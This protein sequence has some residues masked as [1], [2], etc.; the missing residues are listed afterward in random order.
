MKL[1]LSLILFVLVL[2]CSSETSISEDRALDVFCDAEM[3]SGTSF[4][5]NGI[6]FKGA[7]TQSTDKARSGKYSS[8]LNKDQ[9]FGFT[10]EVTNVKKG[11]VIEASVWKHTSGNHG[12][13]VI[14]ADDANNDQYEF[15]QFFND[16]Q[17]GW[18]LI[19][20]FFVAMHDYDKVLVYALCANEEEAYFDDFS[21]KVSRNNQ[22]PDDSHPSLEINISDGAYDTLNRFREIALDQQ[23]ITSNLK[24]YINASLTID[25]EDVP[26]ELRLKGDWTDHLKTNKWSFRIKVRKG[27][28]YKGMRTFS[29]QNPITRSFMHEWFAHKIFE[30]EDILTTR[31]IFVPVIINGEKK[32]VYAL[33]EHF[34]KQ[35]L[36]HRKRREGPIVKFD[37]NGVW[38]IHL[39]EKQSNQSQRVPVYQSAEILPFKKNRTYKSPTLTSQFRVAQS[40]MARY[41]NHDP[42][43]GEY[44]DIDA[45]S[46]FIA[47]SDIVNGK[48]GIIWHNQRHYY[49]PV[50]TKLEPI[51]FDC[52]ME[53]NLLTYQ[54]EMFGLGIRNS[55]KLDE[56]EATLLNKE[57]EQKYYEY[58]KKYSSEA[59]IETVFEALEKQI[60]AAEKLL[61][62]EFPSMHL[63]RSFFRKNAMQIRSQLEEYERVRV[64][65]VK[66]NTEEEPF[67]VLGE[68]EIYTDI[69]V[70]ANLE[71]RHL[72]GSVTISLRNYHSSEVE[73]FGYSTKLDK[74]TIVPFV[75]KIRAF[76]TTTD[77]IYVTFPEKPRRLHYR[78]KN[79]PGQ[80]F[81][82]KINKWGVPKTIHTVSKEVLRGAV[83]E[84]GRVVLRGKHSLSEDL[85]VPAGTRLIIEAGAEI[86]LKNNAAIV[87]HS[88]ITT[89]GTETAPVRIYSSDKTS[90]GVVV[91]SSEHSKLSHTTFDHLGS[92]NK[93]NW[94]LTGAVT[95]YGGEV[96]IENCTFSN[97]SCEDALN[98]IRCHFNIE[99]STVSNTYSDGFDADFCNGTVKYSTF[100]NTGND[101]IDFSGS[102]IAI[103]GCKIIQAGDKGISGGEGSTLYVD[104]CTVDGAH[105]AFA[106][107]DLSTVT[108][109]N[110]SIFRAKYGFAAYRKKPEYGPAT[111]IVEN[112]KQMNAVHLDLLEK[113]SLMKYMS[114]EYRGKKMFDIDAMYA[115]YAK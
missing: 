100:K 106:S 115:M 109:S 96:L 95:F 53:Q 73:L 94:T 21:V 6:E 90:N 35:L 77:C 84:G 46:K 10:Y 36:E 43:V 44:F 68:N 92:M 13:L 93:N 105:I 72:D 67:E 65:D 31:Y 75:Q 56:L 110:A 49:N 85:V 40:H 20:A 76:G 27:H 33:E 50:T 38:Q 16:E 32:G 5:T 57:V 108:I 58:V 30:Y 87:S 107:K 61:S 69:A 81:K 102:E 71:K 51:A 55:V 12:G 24:E 78:A 26:I 25:G 28:A 64:K 18:G 3:V 15:F 74:I 70:K 63:D 112:M 1:V 29:I 86:N 23:V 97:N 14:S 11:D 66:E 39:K 45:L 47:L 9:P 114:K 52:F 104:N 19:N 111:I 2:G 101:C 103:S 62:Y 60:K 41:R 98:L 22:M 54:A 82:A 88:P 80:T 37:E 17:E 91:L 7:H 59:Y 89:N 34:D 99:Y 113:G 8:K 42:D 4:L 79:C 48:H 83:R